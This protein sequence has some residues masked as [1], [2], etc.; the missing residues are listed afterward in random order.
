MRKF[1]RIR[2]ESLLRIRV[3]GWEVLQA[4]WIVRLIPVPDPHCVVGGTGGGGTGMA[5]TLHL[6]PSVCLPVESEG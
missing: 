2:R 6:E 1:F 3:Q 4:K 5:S